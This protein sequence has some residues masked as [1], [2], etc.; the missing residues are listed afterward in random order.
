MAYDRA[1]DAPPWEQDTHNHPLIKG[2]VKVAA[3]E[4]FNQILAGQYSYGTR[5]SAE[6]EL[7]NE[8]KVSRLVI[9]QAI[10]FLETYDVVKRRPNSG[11]FVTYRASPQRPEARSS[12]HAQSSYVADVNSIIKSASPFEMNVMCSILEPEMVRLAALYMSVRDLE[13]LHAILEEI[14][15]IVTDAELFAEKEKLFMTAIAE[16]THN[17]LMITIYRIITMVR[18]QPQWCMTRVQALTP[19][20]IAECQARFRSIYQALA[21]RDIESAVEFMK[22]IIVGY[23]DDLLSS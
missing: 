3:S 6:R 10:D 1:G 20:R 23:Q 4:I 8:L 11:T 13:D 12:M 5:L 18:R 22:L 2:R 19:E 21:N 15:G 9:R 14:E 17:R 16:G 7:A